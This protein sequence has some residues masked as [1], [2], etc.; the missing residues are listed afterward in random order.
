MPSYYITNLEF[1]IF[2]II[3]FL[4]TAPATSPRNCLAMAVSSTAINV[5]WLVPVTPNG[6]VHHYTVTYRPVQSLSGQTISSTQ[7][8]TISTTD[9]STQQVLTNLLKATSYSFTL[10]AY[11]V[12]GP[13]PSSTSQCVAHTQ[14][15][16]ED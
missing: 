13:G 11:T 2:Y 14:E 12:V 7:P 5:T 16:S 9:N 10:I 8:T 3:F 15:D 6:L 4:C 1:I